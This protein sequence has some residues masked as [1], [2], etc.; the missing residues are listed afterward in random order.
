MAPKKKVQAA[1]HRPAKHSAA[2][3]VKSVPHAAAKAQPRVAAKAQAHV[4]AKAQPHVVAKPQVHVAAKP[5][6]QVL[7]KPQL[8]FGG[9]AALPRLT[10]AKALPKQKPA[11]VRSDTHVLPATRPGASLG[12]SAGLL[13]FSGTR[14]ASQVTV[15]NPITEST[16]RLGGKPTPQSIPALRSRPNVLAAVAGGTS[17]APSASPKAAP[18][19]TPKATPSATP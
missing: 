1:T 5:Q 13:R 18:S 10:A 8:S 12:A 9:G 7:P 3:S 19:A 17:V 2:K 4:A 11:A 14:P 15:E 16:F 6:A